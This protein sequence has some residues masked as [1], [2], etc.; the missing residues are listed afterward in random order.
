MLAQERKQYQ[1]NLVKTCYIAQP[2]RHSKI[3]DTKTFKR[4]KQIRNYLPS[5]NLQKQPPEVFY[6]KRCS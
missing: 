5:V 2:F 4:I 6:E 1:I 3:Q